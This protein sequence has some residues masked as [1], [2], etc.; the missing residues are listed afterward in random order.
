MSDYLGN[1]IARTVSPA[2]PLHPR[3]PSLFEPAP[4]TRETVSWAEFEQKNFGEQPPVTGSSEKPAPISLPLSIPMV[5]QSVLREAEQ[6]VFDIS[7]ARDVLETNRKSVAA[8]QLRILS[9]ATPV[10]RNEKPPNSSRRKSDII[11]SPQRDAIPSASHEVRTR[12]ETPSQEPSVDSKAA[13]VPD[14]HKHELLNWSRI[15]PLVPTVR[16]SPPI[17]PLPLVPTKAPPTISVTIGRV[18]V[19]AVMPH[20]AVPKPATRSAPKLSLEEYLKQRNGSRS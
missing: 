3:L 14:L 18:E 1:M 10:L 7:R 16:S 20:V 19:R 5:R 11:L 2:V 8:A 4:A 12:K 15:Q 13:V 6:T 17:A 9:R